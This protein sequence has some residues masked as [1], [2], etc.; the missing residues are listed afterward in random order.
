MENYRKKLKVETIVLAVVSA[1]LFGVQ[2]LAF[3]GVVQPIA[4]DSR[5]VARWNGFVAGA[6]MGIV[7]MFLVGIIGN[8]GALRNEAKLKKLYAKTN[9]ERQEQICLKAQSMGMRISLFLLLA[10]TIV[11]GYFDIK[12][13]LVCLCCTFVQSVITALCKLYWNKVM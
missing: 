3:S 6:S 2:I 8:I 1:V 4:G 11:L 9:D 13:S 10:A 12:M 5:W 7:A